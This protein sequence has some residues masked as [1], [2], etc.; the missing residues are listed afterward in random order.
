MVGLDDQFPK[1]ALAQSVGERQPQQQA[2]KQSRTRVFANMNPLCAPNE[3]GH[4]ATLPSQRLGDLDAA[5]ASTDHAPSLAQVGNAVIPARRMK[6]GA[7]KTVT[8]G[9]IWIERLWRKPVAA[10]K[11]SATTT[12]PLA[13]RKCQRSSA[14]RASTISSLN[15]MNRRRPRSEATFLMYVCISAPGAYLRDQ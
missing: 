12:S 2:L 13:V 11:T 6:S 3:L 7:C 4:V 1:L 15:R 9:D 5:R 8:P 14:K 10:M